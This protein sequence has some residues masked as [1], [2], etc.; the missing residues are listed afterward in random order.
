MIGE[1][2]TGNTSTGQLGFYSNA[3]ASLTYNGDGQD[4]TL[5]YPKPVIQISTTSIPVEKHWEDSGN[6]AH[7]GDSITVELYYKESETPCQT[8]TLNEK[9]SWQTQ[10]KNIPVGSEHSFTVKECLNEDQSVYYTSTVE[11][12]E[13]GFT[14]INTLK[15]ASFTFTKVDADSNDT[16]LA[17]AKFELWPAGDDW[18][19][20]SN[21]DKPLYPTYQDNGESTGQ[22]GNATFTDIPF[23]NYLLYEV[24]APAGY[25]LP[26]DPVRVT[27]EVG[28]SCPL[29]G[30]WALSG[31]PPAGWRS[32]ARL[33]SYISS[34]AKRGRN[35]T[36]QGRN[37]R[38]GES[39]RQI[40][41]PGQQKI[42][43][44]D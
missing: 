11:K 31:S 27:V 32:Q 35:N 33:P 30:A 34:S 21:V 18:V 3:T 28:M 1:T 2:N 5:L 38:K 9:N 39:P 15:V 26:T 10:F 29:L 7:R 19:K 43:K 16:L 14:I 37:M 22:D 41:D 23:G 36:G 24:K 13:S 20:D 42:R 44:R 17:G 6:T 40:K 4:K 12:N 25:K 8:V